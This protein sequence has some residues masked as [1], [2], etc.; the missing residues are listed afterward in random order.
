MRAVA[1]AFEANA[2]SS[3]EAAS[4]NEAAASEQFEDFESERS[5][6]L[7]VDQVLYS[8]FTGRQTKTKT[9]TNVRVSRASSTHSLTHSLQ[10][11]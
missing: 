8:R 3:T 5:T 2:S 7:V 11:T 10:L 1:A 6:P 4:S 9:A